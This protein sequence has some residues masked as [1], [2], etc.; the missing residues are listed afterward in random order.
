[1]SLLNARR[2]WLWLHR[3]TGLTLGLL[4]AF[5]AL[6]GALMT[7]LRPLDAALHPELFRA[8]AT[9]AESAE[10][11]LLEP[12]RQRLAAE[13]GAKASLTL[14]PPREPGESLRVALKSPQWQGTLYID[15]AS[16]RELGRRGETEGAANFIFELHSELLLGDT[17]KAVLAGVALAYLALLLTGLILWWPSTAAQWRHAF[18]LKLRKG[19]TRALFDLHR[20]GGAVIGLLIAVSV[21][22]GAWMAWRP[23]GVWVSGLAGETAP[24]PPKVGKAE[25]PPLTLDQIVAQAR[26][27]WPEAMVGYVQLGAAAT[28]RPVRVRFKLADDPHPNGLSSVWLHPVD[29]R[30]LAQQ[31][32]SALDLGGRATA[33]I[34]PLH[35]G[36]L[37]GP[38]H[39]LA[40]GL[41]GLSLFGL[42]LSGTWLWWR[43]RR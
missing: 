32:W 34:Y 17:G 1:M 36:E 15:P 29:G 33:V 20:F 18:A 41:V 38:L 40:T 26:Q 16:G 12:L 23:L 5:A 14:R 19:A 22:S 31:R 42:G 27:R 43:R 11:A 21:A 3:W 13:F 4:L 8:P 30:V 28:D 39:Q 24:K 25:G 10:P 35:T 37:G 7:V 6:L 2:A 9:G